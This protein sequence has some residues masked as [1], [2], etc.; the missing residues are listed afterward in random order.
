MTTARHGWQLTGTSS[1][2]YEEFLV[3]AIFAPWAEALVVLPDLQPGERVLD[4]ACGTG[5]VARAAAP[6]V[7][8]KGTVTAVDVNPGMLAIARGSTPGQPAVGWREADVIELPFPDGSFD[9]VFCQQGL[10]FMGDRDAAACEMRRVLVSSGRVAVSVWRRLE[11]NRAFAIFAET[12]E[13]FS[14]AAGEVMRSPFGF[15]YRDSLRDV[16]AEAGFD[17]V[18]IT[19]QAKVCRFPSPVELLRQEMLASPLGAPLGELETSA[20]DALIA[21]LVD[22]LDPYVDDDGLAM[23]MESHMAL[24]TGP[25]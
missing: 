2:A 1:E 5:A 21:D 8:S 3:P 7:G 12:L 13:R 9:V 25:A 24:A 16:L 22:A 4:A 18:R 19:V 17:H 10:Q 23:P 14:G 20:M 15:G 6:R 11:H